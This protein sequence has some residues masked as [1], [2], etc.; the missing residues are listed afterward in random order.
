MSR[1]EGVPPHHV[2]RPGPHP[3]GRP[4][5]IATAF[6]A[7][8]PDGGGAEFIARYFR[9]VPIDELT[10]RSPRS[11]P[12]AAASHLALAR[13]R[14]PGVANVRVYNPTTE[15]DGLVQRPHRHPGRHRR[16]AVP[17]RLGHRRA[18]RRRQRHPPRRPPAARRAPRRRRAASRTV[19]DRD[20]DGQG[21][22]GRR[23]RG[24]RVVDAARGRPRER[25]GAPRRARRA[26]LRDVLDDV[27]EAVED[28]PKMRSQVPRRSPPSSRAPRPRASTPT[29][30]AH[31]IRLPALAGR[32]PL[33]LPRLPR[34][35]PRRTTED[36]EVLAPV[37]AP[38]WASCATTRR[39]AR[40]RRPPQPEARPRPASRSMLVLTKANSRSTVHRSTY[41]DY[42]GVKALRR[43]RRR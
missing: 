21:G 28:W 6:E 24:R 29:R 26:R 35:H 33:H 13:D 3:R 27:R 9:H 42:V 18:R 4:R 37:T 10:S 14:H 36:G 12:G 30:S 2:E 19:L 23:R 41:L 5:P 38:A 1:D 34:V 31:A 20:A 32:R 39:A 16:H 15:V 7:V 43:R 11:T 8:A 22:R 40:S 17:R 25:R